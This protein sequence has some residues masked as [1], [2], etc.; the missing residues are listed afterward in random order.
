[1][2]IGKVTCWLLRIPH[3]LPLVKQQH[4]AVYN[5]VEIEADD[6]LK[7]YAMALYPMKHGVRDYINREAAT[8]LKGMDAMRPED[9]R[10]QLLWETAGKH[11]HGAW[12]CA[13]SLIDI[14]LWDLK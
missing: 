8:L 2:K 6:G 13:A 9:I 4:H 5:F 10:R 3:M 7:G 1:M 12:N 14:A 11:F